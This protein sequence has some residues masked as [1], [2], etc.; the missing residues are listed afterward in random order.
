MQI[1]LKKIFETPSNENHLHGYF[2]ISQ[3]SKDNNFLLTTQINNIF[4]YHKKNEQFN[5]CLFNLKNKNKQ[6]IAKTKIMNFQQGC[7]AQFLGPDFQER[8]IFNDFL[9]DKYI[10]KLYSIK[11]QKIIIKKYPIASV[12][13][14]G[15]TYCTLDYERLYWY[16]RGYSYELIK[17]EEKKVSLL[18]SDSLKIINF[19]NDSVYHE[20]YL[21]DLIKIKYLSSMK[22]TVHYIEH[23]LYSPKGDK[24][25]FLHRWKMEDKGIFARL[26]LFDLK[27]KQI[28]LINDSGRISHFTWLDNDNIIFYGAVSNVVNSIRKFKFGIKLFKKILPIYKKLIKDNYAAAKILTNDKYWNFN[29]TNNQFQSIASDLKYQDGHPTAFCNKSDK[30]LITDEYADIDN[31]SNASLFY[32]D[33]F[34]DKSFKI[35]KLN[36]IP[37][38]DNTP[39][40]CDLHPRLSFDGKFVSV[41]TLHNG[42]RQSFVYEII[43][44]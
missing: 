31:E 30:F 4:D 5:I 43:K 8:I 14:M 44:V 29:C 22:D 41:D 15:E 34:S 20:I 36:S 10:S 13:P 9:N 1:V 26:Y 38:L 35:C 28:T 3:L 12:C 27:T 7:R 19:E 2:D 24:L 6:I 21:V 40:R 18:K 23:P 33:F 16:R 25:I 32:Y 17:N 11:N 39:F 37:K 42:F